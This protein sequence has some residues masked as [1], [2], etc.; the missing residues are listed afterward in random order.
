MLIYVLQYMDY[1]DLNWNTSGSKY[2]LFCT[3]FHTNE[4]IQLLKRL[5][6]KSNTMQEVYLKNYLTALSRLILKI[7]FE[8][9]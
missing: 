4:T 6:R 9:H 1:H 8:I 3:I 5:D 7:F 2:S